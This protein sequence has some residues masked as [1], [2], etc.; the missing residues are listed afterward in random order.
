MSPACQCIC[1]QKVYMHQHVKQV[2]RAGDAEQDLILKVPKSFSELRAVRHTLGLYQEQCPAHVCNPPAR[3]I[4]LHAGAPPQPQLPCQRR[5]GFCSLN[6]DFLHVP[7]CT[8][9]LGS[10][11]DLCGR[12]S[13]SILSPRCEVSCDGCAG[14]LWSRGPLS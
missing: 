13:Y 14:F 3:H 10:S 6:L 1:L 5:P 7:S 12:Q 11:Q 2:R 9:M 4:P 8:V